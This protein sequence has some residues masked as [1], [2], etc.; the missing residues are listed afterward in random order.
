MSRL[1]HRDTQ[2]LRDLTE[3]LGS[4]REGDGLSLQEHAEPL[5]RLLDTQHVVAYQIAPLNDSVDLAWLAGLRFD[6]VEAG[7]FLRSHLAAGRVD[8]L[9]YNPIRPEPWQRN[10]AV[11]FADLRPH[12]SESASGPYLEGLRALLGTNNQLRVLLCEGE[13][14]LSWTGIFQPDPFTPRQRVLLTK[15]IEPL[16][17]RLIV[18]RML[19]EAAGIKAALDVAFEAISAPAFLL[20]SNGAIRH[21]NAAGLA[22]LEADSS[23]APNLRERALRPSMPGGP[24]LTPIRSPSS[25]LQYLAVVRDRGDGRTESKLAEAARAWR[26]T[27][28]QLEVLRLLVD[29]HANTG[30]CANLGIAARTAED[31]IRLM[32]RKA[33]VASRTELVAKV[34]RGGLAG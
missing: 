21:A 26:L 7:S 12:L 16:R 17:K 28:K 15:L 24:Q 9:A 6:V 20:A 1:S 3:A 2:Q 10:R 18:E 8:F 34:L 31:H 19:G 33:E 27:R 4:I 5:R 32:F 30:I 22:L 11:E 29:G 23:I 14:L 13:S 25:S